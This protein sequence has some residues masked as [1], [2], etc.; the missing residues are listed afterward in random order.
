MTAQS[1]SLP[2]RG[3]RRKKTRP[4][5]DSGQQPI[6]R[7]PGKAV[8]E[9]RLRGG[10][11]VIAAKEFADQVTSVRFLVL[12]IVLSLAAAAAVYTTAGALRD[13]ASQASGAPSLFLVIFTTRV[14][15]I[16]AFT[17][18]IGFLGPLLGIA[19]GF[20]GIN[21]ERSE[22]TLP[23][24]LAQPIHRDDVINGKFV[25]GLAAIG[26]ILMAVIGIVAAIGVIQLGILPSAES[27][28]RV[29]I[30]FIL[31][32]AY[33]GFWLAFALLCSVVLRRA[34]TSA[35]TALAVWLVL[36][37]FFGLLV[38]LAAGVIAPIPADAGTGSRE[39]LANA[40]LQTNLR[41]IAPNQLFQEATSVIL[42]PSARTVSPDLVTPAQASQAIGGLLPL[43]QSLLVVWGQFTAL[44]AATIG[45]FAVAYVMFMRQEVRA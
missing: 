26:V 12:T 41:R 7:A 15:D 13:V 39:S 16:P 37:A 6:E 23:R 20:D 42:D 22:G 5:P 32:L 18:F 45:V 3:R 10:W 11:R 17:T 36:S 25:A 28:L 43:D 44:V 14:G 30:W 9:P 1:E 40:A 24:L 33:I 34:A 38:G 31:A 35:L 8:S 2:V 4:G 19:F 27:V 21:G 29:M